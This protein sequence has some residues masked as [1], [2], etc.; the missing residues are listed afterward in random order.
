MAAVNAET[1]S[2]LESALNHAF[3]VPR[4]SVVT[5]VADTP[6]EIVPE[7]AP[8]V[9]SSEE[10]PTPAESSPDDWKVEHDAQIQ[11]LRAEYAVAREK[12]ETERRRWKEIRAVKGEDPDLTPSEVVLPRPPDSDWE[13]VSKQKPSTSASTTSAPHES[14][15]SAFQKE[16]TAAGGSLESSTA[17][18]QVSKQTTEDESSKWEDVPSSM[19]SSSIPSMSFPSDT[20][21]KPHPK[22][23]S[24]LPSATLSVFDASLPFKARVIALLSSLSINLLLPFINGVMLGFGE[25]FAKEYV[26]GWLGWRTSGTSVASVGIKKPTNES[27]R[28]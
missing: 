16:W 15:A 25:I 1:G 12:A 11:S 28:W 2:V 13:S 8:A 18:R 20:P 9:L 3:D 19:N 17:A 24:Q 23:V 6:D 7:P 5:K 26:V 21:P 4:Q 22:Q 27:R 14:I 10:Q